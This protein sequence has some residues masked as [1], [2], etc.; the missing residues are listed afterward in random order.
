VYATVWTSI[1]L[2][3]GVAAGLTFDNPTIGIAVTILVTAISKAA[4]EHLANKA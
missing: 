1:Q 3:C 4:R 2:A